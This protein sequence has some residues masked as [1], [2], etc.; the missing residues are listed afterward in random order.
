LAVSRVSPSIQTVAIATESSVAPVLAMDTLTAPDSST[1][2]R[3]V[4]TN[5]GV[6]DCDR[7][8]GRTGF[9]EGQLNKA[10]DFRSRLPEVAGLI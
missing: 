7:S 8:P 6:L 3:H 1:R 5:S 2:V 9:G 10:R 4:I